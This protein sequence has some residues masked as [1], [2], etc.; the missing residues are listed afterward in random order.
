MIT[1]VLLPYCYFRFLPILNL[2]F[3]SL[4]FLCGLPRLLRVPPGFPSSLLVFAFAFA[5]A[6]QLLNY[7]ITQL[8]NLFHFLR[9]LRSSVLKVLILIW[10]LVF[11]IPKLFSVSE[12]ARRGGCLRGA[13][14]FLL[15]AARASL[16]QAPASGDALTLY[17]Q[18]LQPAFAAADVH[19]IRNVAIDREDLHIVFT[20]GVIG[21]MQ[22][23]E[24][25]VTGAF[26]AGDGQI[27][28][29]PPD[30]AERTSL[31]LFIQSGVLDTPFHSAYLRFFDDKLLQELRSGFR[32]EENPGENINQWKQ[33]AESLAPMDGLHLLQAMTNSAD[34]SSRFLH[35]RLGETAYGPFDVI[36]NTNVP[37]QV[38]VAQAAL[39]GN[40]SFYNIW[41][42][43]P[44]RS[45]REPQKAVSVS[46][47]PVHAS[48]FRIHSKLF[49]PSNVEGET[50]MTLVSRRSGQRTIIL[51]LSRQLKVTEAR[52]DGQ[53]VQFIQNEAVRGSDL[54]RRG[55]DQVAIVFPAPLEKDHPAKL[56]LKYSGPVMF[57]AGGELIYVGAR[58]TWYPNLGPSFAN[59][60]LT[61]EYPSDWT[62]VATG[63]RVSSSAQNGITTSRFV[64][65]RIIPHAGFNLGKFEVATASAGNVA[66]DAYAAKTVEQSLSQAE[67][68]AGLHP[69]PSNQV[70]RI[71]RQAA[72]GVQFLSR[73]LDAFPY[74]NLEIA[75]LPASLSQS[76][77]GLIYLSSLAYLTP[78]ERAAL[79]IH[80]P[81]AELL[82][83]EM[84]LGHEIGHQWW[85]DA[86]DWESYRDAWIVEAMANYC[87]AVMLERQD[88]AKMKVVLD[89]YRSELLKPV[90]DSMIA[91]AGP[92]TLGPRLNSS[93]F[94]DAYD[95]VVYGRG[96]WLLH[97]LR[98][99]LRQAD[100]T[101]TD[102]LFFSA[103]KG[104]LSK[105]LNGKIST[106][107]LQR[108]FEQ[109]LPA[110]L[111]YEG[112]KSLDWFFD[113]WVNGAAIPK[114]TLEDV[115]LTPVAGKVKVKG[116][117]SQ[118][119][120]AKDM[121]TAVP[122]YAV[123]E[124]GAQHFLAFVF[125]DDPKTDF[126][127]TAPQ[128]T[129]AI[130]LDPE[131]TILKR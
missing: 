93:K 69:D 45:M 33:L 97:M 7:Q 100:G 126:E 74:P 98:T 101:D 104:L 105:S 5:F 70:Q 29:L 18:F 111:S 129:K 42:S 37:E 99:M 76:W 67:A 16:A 11:P 106:R 57:D 58:G 103:L 124:K 32:P 14:L 68:R 30:R 53:P 72:A 66:I 112:Q 10:G 75:Q 94:P 107:E 88:P 23:V 36:F 80:D 15:V 62:L 79:G 95:T 20:D 39:A 50:E 17:R 6:L 81:F 51:Q 127:L 35:L 87:A 113:S 96:T 2:L 41:T 13:I 31:A 48:D 82:M 19:H 91:D 54:S 108:A 130:L 59:F 102:A 60:D 110:S 86:V 4:M 34:A 119:F 26:F 65:D 24:G 63:R 12:P 109:V 89:H 120:E 90:G 77:P 27:L 40:Q 64:S 118:E 46:G 117:I 44:M 114:F 38:S 131:N 123:D 85:G 55:N 9:C 71:A 121:V 25:H 115:Q 1:R 73:E 22:S 49:P 21:M 47:P 84:M 128:G 78:A 8:L 116:T 125:A 28:L 122:I 3:P 52:L 56:L 61:F 92:V 43:F 83:G